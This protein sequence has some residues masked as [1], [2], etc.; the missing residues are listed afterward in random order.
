[1]HGPGAVDLIATI[2]VSPGQH[3]E[4]LRMLQEYGEQ[5]RAEPG[6]LRFE[7]Y[8]SDAPGRSVV[9]LERYASQDAFDAHLRDPANARFNEALA[10]L[11]GG[12]ASSLELLEA[13]ASTPV[14]RAPRPAR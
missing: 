9:V 7:V 11:T 12:A 5:V 6:N 8:S 4:V 1:M 2:D 13:A 3:G 10:R 14:T